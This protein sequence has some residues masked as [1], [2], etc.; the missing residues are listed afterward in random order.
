LIVREPDGSPAGTLREGAISLV[1]EL[2]PP[3]SAEEH[4]SALAAVQRRLHAFGI[5]AWQDASVYDTNACA[6]QLEAYRAAAEAGS[7]AARVVAALFWDPRR[8]VE[9][10]DGFVAQR[11][12]SSVGRLRAGTVKIWV[13]GV[14]EGLTG[15]MLDPYLD[16][17]GQVTQNRGMALVPPAGLQDAVVALDRAGLQVHL[18][19]IGD[20]AVRSSLDAI[21][22]ARRVNGASDLRHHIAH[23][24][25]I[26]PAD[27]PR[28]ADLGA[29]ANMQ[30]IWAC[31][32]PTMDER[33]I[34]FLGA[35]RT[36]WQ[37]PF[38]S[39]L[40]HGARLAAGSDWP[41][42]SAN[43]ML[44][45]EV[46][47]TRISHHDR[48]GEP[49]VPGER[50]SLDQALAAF[51]IGSAYVNHLNAETGSIEV[52]KLADLVLLDRNLRALGAAPI[53]EARVQ[54]TWVEGTEV[55]TRPM[56]GWG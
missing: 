44:E 23:I 7:L 38:A 9:Q 52:G 21:E 17:Q 37:Y 56:Q 14:V 32:E 15:A 28:F 22:V 20:A 40:R 35:G 4:A 10:V 24:Q 29:T 27:L 36:T 43:P 51:T 42:T 41:V 13:D 50:L 26:H 3:A 47:V 6:L 31:H 46:A 33:T 19:A 2:V 5:T 12:S 53:G 48:S 1:E 30:P 54:A 25:V 45:I 16:E 8:G 11:A 34:P 55:Y 49:F 18:H 39:L